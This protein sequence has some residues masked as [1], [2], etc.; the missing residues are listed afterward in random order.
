MI[1]QKEDHLLPDSNWLQTTETM[2][3]AATDKGGY[4]SFSAMHS[5]P[6]PY[7]CQI[8]HWPRTTQENG[9]LLS[10]A[11][12]TIFFSNSGFGTSK[13]RQAL[14][15]FKECLLPLWD[16][17]PIRQRSIKPGKSK[18]L[19][20]HNKLWSNSSVGYTSLKQIP[21]EILFLFFI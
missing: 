15:I 3:S 18:H 9:I 17:T 6:I 16:K 2:G 14:L 4:H 7:P 12:S 20:S 21:T 19:L 8:N 1:P 13:F 10:I 5:L 11:A